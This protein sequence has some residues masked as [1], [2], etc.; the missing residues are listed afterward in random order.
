M[1][2]IKSEV[3]IRK[4]MLQSKKKETGEVNEFCSIPY[5]NV[6]GDLTEDRM[7]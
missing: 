2:L 3:D 1:H 5:D 6:H 7:I 4:M